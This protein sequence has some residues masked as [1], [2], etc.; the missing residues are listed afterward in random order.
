MTLDLIKHNGPTP[1]DVT[2]PQI[3]TDCGNVTLDFK[4]LGFYASLVF[5]QTV[6]SKWNDTFTFIFG[7][8]SN[9]PVIFQH[10][11]LANF[12]LSVNFA[13]N[14]LWYSTLWTA[15]PF[16]NDPLWLTLFVEGVNDRLLDHCQVSSVPHCCAFKEQEIPRIYTV[17]MVIYWN[18]NVNILI[19][20]DTDFWLSLAVSSNHQN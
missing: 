13:F 9:S 2:A 17:W 15:T 10:I 16:S 4:Q 11:S 1:A 14:M 19:F 18:S 5:L 20:W 3:I 8:L 12:F 7:P 6:I